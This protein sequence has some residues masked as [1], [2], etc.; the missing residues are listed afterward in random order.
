MHELT[1]A[2]ILRPRG[3]SCLGVRLLPYSIG[4]EATLLRYR[5]ALLL[6]DEGDFND[7]SLSEQ[8]NAIRA[9]ALICSMDWESSQKEQKGL[10]R[11]QW[12]TRKAD[13]PAE[14]ATFR[15]YLSD[16]KV[17]F[18][19]PSAEA[20][21]SAHGIADGEEKPGRQPG[22]PFL[23]QIAMFSA[24][25]CD[26]FG[27]SSVYDFPYALATALYFAKAEEDGRFRIQNHK[28]LEEQIAIDKITQEV[29]EEELARESANLATPLPNLD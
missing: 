15:N 8:I 23:A 17:C 25:Y 19:S 6:L 27:F 22:A 16:A 20:Y 28:E 18:P 1:F 11:W 2:D 9:A 3:Y 26:K 12:F 13:Y 14:I 5:N 21:N 4:H 24:N 7:L 10:Y 29:R